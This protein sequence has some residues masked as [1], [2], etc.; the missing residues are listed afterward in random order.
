DTSASLLKLWSGGR[1]DRAGRRKGFVVS[2]YALA[3]VARGLLALATA[4]WQMFATRVGDRIGKGIRTAPR[5][6]LIADSTSAG[7]RGRAFD[8]LGAAIGPLLAAAFLWAWP[9]RLRTLFLLAIVPGLIV[10]ALLAIGLREPP[11]SSPSEPF[12]LTLRPFGRDFR[13]LLLALIVF[14]LGNASDAFLL[15]RAGE[16][17]VP[18]TQLPILWCI[19]HVAKSAGSWLAGPA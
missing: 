16:L 14:T 12:R 3:T 19:F 17:G 7:M 10:V 6:A 11:T 8:R 15:V 13:L 2:G 5:D 9:G 1:S 4:P 18:A